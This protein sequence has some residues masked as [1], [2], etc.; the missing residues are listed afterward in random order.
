MAFLIETGEFKMKIKN[1]ISKA[2]HLAIGLIALEIASIPVSAQIIGKFTVSE[3]QRLSS[4]P[5]PPEAGI[6]K[7]LVSSNTP[8][9]IVSENAI[10]EFDVSIKVSGMLNGNSFGSNAQL[11]GDAVSCA[12]QTA[13]TAT[14]IY[15][16]ERKTTSREGDVLTRAII[17]E[18]RYA[19][20]LKP[21]L[22]IVPKNKAKKALSSSA[23]KTKLT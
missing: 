2:P 16:A 1:L 8:F 15:E 17:V 10:G 18:I 5:F 6:T 14:K 7:F 9:A 23:C 22:T 12:A 19:D 21:E 3:P 4:A 11:P 13:K 20:T